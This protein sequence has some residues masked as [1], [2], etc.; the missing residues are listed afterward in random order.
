MLC[1]FSNSK[2]NIVRPAVTHRCDKTYAWLRNLSRDIYLTTY[3]PAVQAWIHSCLHRRSVIESISRMFGNVSN[4]Y[5]MQIYSFVPLRAMWLTVSMTSRTAQHCVREWRA[6]PIP[7]L[8]VVGMLEQATGMGR[9]YVFDGQTDM[10]I[11]LSFTAPFQEIHVI[12]FSSNV[13]SMHCRFA[14][15][16]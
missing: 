11:H 3:L 10:M 4:F 13:C 5:S 14:V 7:C 1:H 12:I 16:E 8:R 6:R 2:K 9:A 15:L